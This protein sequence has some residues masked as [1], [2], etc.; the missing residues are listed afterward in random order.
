M[1]ERSGDNFKSSLLLQL[2]LQP[3]PWGDVHGGVHLIQHHAGLGAV[4]FPDVLHLGGVHR[5]LG[6]GARLV[7]TGIDDCQ[8][9]GLLLGGVRDVLTVA[10]NHHMAAGSF[11]HMEP[12]VLAAGGVQG[13]LVVPCQGQRPPRQGGRQDGPQPGCAACG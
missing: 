7:G 2:L 6:T 9:G 10:H 5:H 1:S 13:E 11:L 3:V 12:Q 4:G 8:L